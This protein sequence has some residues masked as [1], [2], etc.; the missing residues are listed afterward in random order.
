MNKPK[1]IICDIDGVLLNH[2]NKGLSEQLK[3]EPVDGA[4]KKLNE[5]DSKGYNIIL[6]T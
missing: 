1:T 2:K 5:W 4:V 3:T 6:I